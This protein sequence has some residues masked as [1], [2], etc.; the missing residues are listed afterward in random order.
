MPYPTLELAHLH[1]HSDITHRA[2]TIALHSTIPAL[3]SQQSLACALLYLSRKPSRRP[4]A[5]TAR[6]LL[7][8]TLSVSHA[9]SRST[10]LVPVHR[11]AVTDRQN[12]A[13][14]RPSAEPRD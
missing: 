10:M 4:L 2:A 9:D 5:C 14:D 8:C 12:M 11:L 3:N 6:P 13:M 7:T 1:S